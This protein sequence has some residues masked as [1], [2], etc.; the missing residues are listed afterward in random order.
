MEIDGQGVHNGHFLGFA[1][2]NLCQWFG[3]AFVVV[4]PRFFG[5]KMALYRQFAPVFHDVIN[6]LLGMFG[7]EAK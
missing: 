7:L 2:H 4:P 5:M 6:I 3:K 1:P